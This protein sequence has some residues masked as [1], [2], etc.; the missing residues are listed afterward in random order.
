MSVIFGPSSEVS[1][2]GMVARVEAL[3]LYAC[4]PCVEAKSVVVGS[5]SSVVTSGSIITVFIAGTIVAEVTG[6]SC[7]VSGSA[8]LV[9]VGEG[10]TSA[11]VSGNKSGRVVISENDSVK[12]DSYVK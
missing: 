6:S 2:L 11:V 3:V 4:A 5:G 9:S 7:V 8:V 12:E 1:V 10:G